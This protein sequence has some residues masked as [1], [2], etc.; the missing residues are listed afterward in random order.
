MCCLLN[1][2]YELILQIWNQEKMPEK[3]DKAIVCP[4]YKKGD[5][6]NCNNYRGISLLCTT[7]KI[8]TN[9][10]Q[11]RIMAYGEDIIGEYQAG[12]RKGRST[13]DQVFTTRQIMEK[14]WEYN[15]PIYQLFI[16]FKEAYDS[17]D[18]RKLYNV[19]KELGIPIKLI[20]LTRMTME[21]SKAMVKIQNRLLPTFTTT[22]G[23]RQGDG[24]APILFNIALEK[25][26]IE[27]TNNIN[28][29]II[30]KSH[31]IIGRPQPGIEIGKRNKRYLYENRN[32]SP[33]DW[34]KR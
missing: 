8:F 24:L 27:S 6:H 21:K 32:T 10:L 30:N 33:K 9:I 11:R 16:D 28:G 34:T 2:I 17:I 4:I 3:W 15:T 20:N 1:E 22:K 31:Q 13:I 19:M 7:Y 29:T 23:V 25:V 12:F 18:R 14:A 26:I 5:K